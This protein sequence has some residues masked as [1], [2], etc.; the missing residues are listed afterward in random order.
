MSD[1]RRAIVVT[2]AVVESGG[3]L[4]VTRRL[5]GTH[6]A[7]HWE[8]PGG[9]CEP[10][11]SPERCLERELSEELGVRSQIGAEIYRTEY[12]YGDRLLDLRFFRCAIAGEPQ[13]VLGQEIRWVLPRELDTLEF[14]PADSELVERLKQGDAGS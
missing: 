10:G 12:A 1:P 8:F 11:E 14:P 6:M 2:A 4:L 7:G 3:R 5:E 9:K 13:P